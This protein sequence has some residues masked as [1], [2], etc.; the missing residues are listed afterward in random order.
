MFG[1]VRRAAWQAANGR[2][3]RAFA[4][5]RVYHPGTVASIAALGIGAAAI[6]AGGA[7][8][9]TPSGHLVSATALATD[10][11]IKWGEAEQKRYARLPGRVLAT[12]VDDGIMLCEWTLVGVGRQVAFWERGQ[13]TAQTVHYGSEIGAQVFLASGLEAILT[14]R[15]GPTHR[16]VRHAITAIVNAGRPRD[17]PPSGG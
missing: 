14:G 4:V 3:A 9:R 13:F 8:V 15:R 7:V 10:R 11:V 2:P 6:G 5:L 1:R 12:V 17:R 16:S